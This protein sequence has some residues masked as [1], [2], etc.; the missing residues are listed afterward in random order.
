MPITAS[1]PHLPLMSLLLP[2]LL[3]LSGVATG[4]EVPQ[5]IQPMRSV[6]VAAGQSVTLPCMVTFPLPVGSVKWFR[7]TE[8]NRQLIYNFKEGHF[9]RI[10]S[11]SDITKR[12]NRNFSIHIS[13][14]TP[15]DAGT[16]YCLM[17]RTMNDDN[18]EMMSGPGTQ[19]LVRKISGPSKRVG[20]GQVLNL[21]CKST[22]FF[23]KNIDVKWF[24]DGVELPAFHTLVF[25]QG[26]MLT[27]TV[28]STTQLSLA[29][30]S[31]YSHVTCQVAHIELQSPLRRHVKISQ[32]I[33]VVPTVDTSTHYIPGL[34][35]VLLTCHVQRFYPE[36]T[37]ITW[38][39]RNGCFK[40]CE[41]SSPT[42]NPDGTFSQDIHILVN[43]SEWEDQR[44]FT[45][46]VWQEIQV[47]VQ[48]SVH[49]SEFGRLRASLGA[50][51]YS[52]IL[53]LGWKLF[54]LMALSTI[55]VLKRSLPS[56]RTAVMPAAAP[57]AS[58]SSAC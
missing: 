44:L 16:Y 5:V 25:L 22:G 28:F 47:L 35:V 55:Y 40:V 37:Q 1:Q 54:P 46:Q 29:F 3:G 2:L 26:E 49:L 11:M 43:A 32:F 31:L 9:P 19:I 20:P 48:K 51:I 50:T 7:G 13:N 56:R 17:L 14:L 42:K 4:E 52:S 58:A 57:S 24:Q 41:T 30:S 15:A 53:L 12:N 38:R 45:C 27:Y 8:R 34:Q 39:E 6:S 36:D 21:T 18:I 10:T 23:P 33:R